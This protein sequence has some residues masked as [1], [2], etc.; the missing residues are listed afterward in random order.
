MLRTR[1]ETRRPP[2]GDGDHAGHRKAALAAAPSWTRVDAAPA[3]SPTDGFLKLMLI[4]LAFFVVLYSRSEVS[5][6]KAGPVL[7]ALADRFAA[8]SGS[9][10][11]NG[12]MD[13][14]ARAERQLRRQLAA[15]LPV[16]ASARE[17][18]GMLIAFVLDERDLFAPS[19][20][21]V[22]R[23]RL[24]LL[25]RLATALAGRN[26][27][28]NTPLMVTTAWPEADDSGSATQRLLALAEVLA[29]NGLA[30]TALRLGFAPVA[31]GTWH[32]AVPRVA[33]RQ[34]HAD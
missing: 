9:A 29:A 30:G 1:P 32:F 2:A 25:R 27:T 13:G 26:A 4:L 19:G 14:S 21:T 8:P 7:E 15:A 17:L 28:W 18:P 6:T 12:P 24:V 16:Q 23:E 34:A 20:D 33:G 31:P 3:E 11:E 10:A 22:R 5:S